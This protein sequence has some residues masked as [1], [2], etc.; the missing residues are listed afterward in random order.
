MIQSKIS[1]LLVSLVAVLSLYAKE[2]QHDPFFNDPF[3][4]DIFK[5]MMQM[6][7]EM[8]KM[9]DR[10]HE[11]MKQR[12]SGLISPLG[13]YKMGTANRFKDKDGHYELHTDIPE[14]KESHIDITTQESVISVT[15]KIIEK[16]KNKTQ[17]SVSRSRSVRMYQQ[18]LP[19]P[20]D[21]DVST[22]KTSYKEGKLLLTIQK[23]PKVEKK[24]S[25]PKE[26]S[27]K[28]IDRT[29]K[30]IQLSD[31]TSMS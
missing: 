24:R 29:E 14:S 6:Q 13:T 19:L 20:D 28:E 22:V 26:T 4:D 9:F 25:A 2:P 3:G 18:S 23:K 21:A 31:K 11:R 30:R 27:S 1:I 15:A 12:S 10:M 7:Q 16:S 17:N 8:D 5:E